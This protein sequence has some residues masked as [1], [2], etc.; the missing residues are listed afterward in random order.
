MCHIG[1][2]SVTGNLFVADEGFVWQIICHRNMLGIRRLDGSCRVAEDFSLQIKNPL[3]LR[4]FGKDFVSL[5]KKG[6]I[7][8]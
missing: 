5:Q 1:V 8:L 2:T 6:E 3:I 7:Q 4:N